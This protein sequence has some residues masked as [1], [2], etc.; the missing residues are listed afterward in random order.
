MLK[1]G[2]I[3]TLTAITPVQAKNWATGECTADTGEKIEYAIHA[4]RG[5]LWINKGKRHDV[6][7]DKEGDIATITLIGPTGN[8][9]IAVNLDTGR[10]AYVSKNDKS[11]NET[12]GNIWCKLGGFTQ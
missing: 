10:G 3:A 2:L 5:F 6:F 1:M 4:G 7:T 8:L 9:V 12:T 11:R